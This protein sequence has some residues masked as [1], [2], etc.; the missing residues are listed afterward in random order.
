METHI[1]GI[2]TSTRTSSFINSNKF[3]TLKENLDN[4]VTKLINYNK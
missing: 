2:I 4:S 1:G 3:K